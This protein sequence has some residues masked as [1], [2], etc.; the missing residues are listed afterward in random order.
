MV[1]WRCLFRGRLRFDN[2]THSFFFK[3]EYECVAVLAKV[4]ESVITV[5]SVYVSSQER[6]AEDISSSY[7]LNVSIEMI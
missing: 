4:H 7:Q 2:L 1:V 3:R 6:N 5:S